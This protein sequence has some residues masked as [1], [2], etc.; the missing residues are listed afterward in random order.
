MAY[1]TIL[2]R[3]RLCKRPVGSNPTVS[4]GSVKEMKCEVCGKKALFRF[5][6][7]EKEVVLCDFVCLTEYC[8]MEA[9]TKRLEQD[10]K[11]GLIKVTHLS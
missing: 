5:M 9:E 1:R 7:N 3:W 4:V 6:V 11:E 2:E 10:E 8:V